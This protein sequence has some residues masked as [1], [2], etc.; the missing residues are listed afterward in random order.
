MNRIS[1][2][3]RIRLTVSTVPEPLTPFPRPRQKDM[4]LELTMSL[5]LEFS[6]ISPVQ[7]TWNI[8]RKLQLSSNDPLLWRTIDSKA[9]VIWVARMGSGHGCL[10]RRTDIKSSPYTWYELTGAYV[11]SPVRARDWLGCWS[12]TLCK[13]ITSQFCRP[14]VR[15]RWDKNEI[16]HVRISA[17][18]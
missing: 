8:G 15:L 12:E 3:L 4:I 9:C 2:Q 14:S 10:S 16:N 17:I 18:P 13:P 7:N 5:S 1:E 11:Y 6:S